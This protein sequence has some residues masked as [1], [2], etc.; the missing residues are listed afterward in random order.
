[1]DRALELAR[2]GPGRTAPTRA[3]AASCSPP[4]AVAT[5]SPRAGTPA[6]GRRTPRSP[7]LQAARARRRRR[8]RAAPPS[9]PSS[10]ATTPAG[11]AR[12]PRRCSTPAWHASS[13]RSPTRTRSRRAARS[14]CGP[15]GSTSSPGCVEDEGRAAAAHLAAG[16]GAQPPVRH[17]EDRHHARRPGRRRRR[18]QPVDHRRGRPPARALPARRLGR[19]RRRHR[20][21]RGRR[22][23]AHRAHRRR[24]AS[25]RTSR[26]GSSSA[27][28][29]CRTTPG[30]ADPAASSCTCDTHDPAAVLDALHAREV[31][32]VL[33]EGG[34]TL[35]AAFLRAGLVDEVHAYIAPV[36]LGAGPSAVGDLGVATIGDA[37]PPRCP[38][39]PTCSWRRSPAPTSPS[40]APTVVP[41]APPGGALMFTGIVEEVGAVVSI[42][43][44]TPDGAGGR[45]PGGT[46]AAS[47]SRGPLV[48][49]RRRARRLDRGRRGVP[50]G[51]RAARRRHVHR[52]RHARVAAPHRRSGRSPRAPRSTSSARVRADARLGGHVVQGHV[53]GVGTIVRRTPG[54]RWDDVVVQLPTELAGY[55]AEK[56][57]IAVSGV[58]LTVTQVG[59]DDASASASSRPRSRRR[60]WGTCSPARRVN[61][62]VDVIAKY[63]ERLLATGHGTVR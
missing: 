43:P 52:R 6:S 27:T 46:D 30:C 16:R 25:S 1:M 38:A 23:V 2:R 41:A 9:S 45:R 22:P 34:P 18:H 55:V 59:P 11:P 10:R 60:R 33:V 37:V 53:D 31:R 62:E 14:A 24:R 3:S 32:H 42:V 57:S 5:C 29:R 40:R 13:S 26:C 35:A 19:D 39:R 50:H 56:G 8:P 63:V 7:A 49:V 36:L 61:L 20:H 44:G 12:A 51:R 47:P 17:P 58:S 28:A 54:P 15:R 48:D 4:A 21:R